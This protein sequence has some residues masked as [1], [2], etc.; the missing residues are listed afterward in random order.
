MKNQRWPSQVSTVWLIGNALVAAAFL[1]AAS[2]TWIEPELADV[3]GASGG[4]GAV[5]FMTAVP[6]FILATVVNF[7]VL[8]WCCV[9]RLK[10]GAWPA[11]W[12][13]WLVVFVWV[14]VLLLDN[15][16]HGA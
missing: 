9:M 7:A 5:W 11:T 12:S 8:T 13:S 6:I 2:H 3:P 10:R 14:A 1:F 4:A 15:S 16:R